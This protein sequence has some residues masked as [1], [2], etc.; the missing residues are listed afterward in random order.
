MSSA[1]GWEANQNRNRRSEDNRYVEVDGE[2]PIILLC[3]DG[4][5]LFVALGWAD[6]T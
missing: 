2:A 5:V 1:R 4:I 6:N 3:G